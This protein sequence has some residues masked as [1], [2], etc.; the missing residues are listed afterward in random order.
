MNKTFNYKGY[1]FNMSVQFNTRAERNLDGKRWHTLITN[2]TGY[3]NYYSKKEVLDED[4]VMV[5]L[6]EER[7]AKKYVDDK[8]KAH[9][10]LDERLA[11]LGFK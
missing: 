8:V 3:D 11:D 4:L 10:I 2:C 1:E 9:T 5:V 7:L 6:E